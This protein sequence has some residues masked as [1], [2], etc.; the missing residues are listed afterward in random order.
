[1]QSQSGSVRLRAFMAATEP[2][3]NVALSVVI[4]AYNEVHRLPAY[5]ETV[6]AYLNQRGLSHEVLV[7]DDGSTDDTARIVEQFSAHHRQP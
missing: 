7:V 4:P 3:T 6:A 5:L 2:R 1:M